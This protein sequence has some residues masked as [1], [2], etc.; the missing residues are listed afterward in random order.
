MVEADELTCSVVLVSM[1]SLRFRVN[2]SSTRRKGGYLLPCEALWLSDSGVLFISMSPS[3]SAVASVP[4][5][6]AFDDVG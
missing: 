4:A 3:A 1:S 6:E 2:C 5:L